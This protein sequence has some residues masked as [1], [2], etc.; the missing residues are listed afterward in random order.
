M[1]RHMRVV[2]HIGMTKAGSSALQAGLFAVRKQLMDCGVF[3]PVR[4]RARNSHMLLLSGLVP[5]ERLPRGLRHLHGDNTGAIEEDM[6]GWL[7]DLQAEI[8]ARRPQ[9]LVL[10]EEFLFYVVEQEAQITLRDRLRSLG[11]HTIDVVVYIRRPSEHYL[12]SIQQLLK[13]SHRIPGPNPIEYRRTI[14]GYTEHVADN[15]VVVKYDRANWPDADILRQFLTAFVPQVDVSISGSGRE[16]NRSLSS[17]AMSLLAEYR[18]WI[19]PDAHNQFTSDTSRLI[20]ALELS[21]IEVGGDAAPRLHDQVA[22]RVDETSTDLL[23]LR[24]T[25]GI[26][27]DGIDYSEIRPAPGR[28][29]PVQCVDEICPIDPDRRRWLT[30][31]AMYHLARGEVAGRWPAM[32]FPPDAAVPSAG[33]LRGRIARLFS[34]QRRHPTVGGG[35]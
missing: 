3:Y 26:T 22:R 17:E 30:S 14:E 4:G 35:G 9:T 1:T 21:D 28:H 29:P 5:P 13:A 16:I 19:W 32:G 15:T 31:R 24:D 10:S 7:L 6:K 11:G 34:K 27:F 2:L 8:R 12:A 23:W 18:R 33:R 25:H 20:S